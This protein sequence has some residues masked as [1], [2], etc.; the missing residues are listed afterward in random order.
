MSFFNMKV[1]LTLKHPP[2][3]AGRDEVSR[4]LRLSA[5]RHEHVVEQ[6]LLTDYGAP[7]SDSVE[8]S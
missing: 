7:Q 2:F 4:I 6:L 8:S 5:I 1:Q 3:A